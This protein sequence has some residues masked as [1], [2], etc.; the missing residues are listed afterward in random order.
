LVIV[1]QQ[2]TLGNLTRIP[3]ASSRHPLALAHRITATGV[4]LTPLRAEWFPPAAPFCYHFRNTRPRAIRDI[5]AAAWGGN[6]ADKQMKCPQCGVNMDFRLG[7]H[8]CPDCG[9]RLSGARSAP[10]DRL[11]RRPD[12]YTT[13]TPQASLLDPRLMRPG[14]APQIGPDNAVPRVDFSPTASSEKAILLAIF[15]GKGLLS[16]FGAV[17]AGGENVLASVLYQVVDVAVIAAILYVSFVPAKWCCA[18]Y[19]CA[20]G[21][22]SMIG[23]FLGGA[24]A[25][26]A[27]PLMGANGGLVVLGWIMGFAEAF[28]HL[29]LASVLYRDIQNIQTN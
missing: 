11:T 1:P 12:E 2:H 5:S 19:S 14:R 16:V 10:G 3:F 23:L 20:V 6:M 24:L 21:V 15:I 29:W 18:T 27:M 28:V 9:H 22:L 13:S 8:E 4:D 26:L 7:E 25:T 17:A